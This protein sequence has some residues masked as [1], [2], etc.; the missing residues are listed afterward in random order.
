MNLPKD[1]VLI[2]C[3]AGAAVSILACS[4]ISNIKNNRKIK[5]RIE[6]EWGNK[7]DRKYTSDN[8]SYISK[9]FYN[10][11]C[12]YKGKF[13]ID[14]ITWND[15]EMD[16]IFKYINSTESTP[17]EECLYVMLRE[18]IYDDIKLKNR[19]KLI[20]FFQNNK[21]KREKIQYNLA[22]LGR[23]RGS[24]ISSYFLN[25]TQKNQ[26]SKLIIYRI[27]S[28][29][30]LVSVGIMFLNLGIGLMS[31]FIS[32]MINSVLHYYVKQRIDYKLRAYSYII[33]MIKC[34]NLILKEN[35]KEIEYY[36]NILKNV[37]KSVKQFKNV[38][39]DLNSNS[40]DASVMISYINIIFL[41]DLINYEKMNKK[42]KTDNEEFKTIFQVLGIIDSSI[43]IASYR[44]RV[45]NYT[46]PELYKCDNKK[47]QDIV[48]KDVRHPLI[49]HGVANSIDISDS[50]LITGSNASG[51][52]TFLK[53]IAVNCIFAQT[54]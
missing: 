51:K 54:I 12:E 6:R 26:E 2:F 8:I 47:E 17:G 28:I 32:F 40:T 45:K 46:I 4:I 10:K 44:C 29:V 37:I 14:E 1:I 27:L 33:Q 16:E 25:Y 30:P 19:N 21:E 20:E 9:Y 13:F 3:L 48:L 42:L 39:F 49:P 18:P 7:L 50:I 11:K 31:L 24:D 52:S 38:H 36:N 53:T 15:L 22:K 43:S 23:K 41:K 35:I 5:R 34:S